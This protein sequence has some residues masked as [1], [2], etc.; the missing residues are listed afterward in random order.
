MGSKASLRTRDRTEKGYSGRIDQQQGRRLYD[1]TTSFYFTNFPKDW[2]ASVLWRMFLLWGKVVDVY[3]PAKRD[4]K[5]G[6]YGFV[7]FIRVEDDLELE[8]RLQQI[9]IG[10]FKLRGHRSKTR[11]G[12]EQARESYVPGL[13]Q[14]KEV[15]GAT[16]WRERG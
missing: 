15:S 10:T 5:G 3:V 11:E 6:R 12:S 7:K 4:K 8:N 14:V 1:K 9:W 13:R 2:N 16:Q